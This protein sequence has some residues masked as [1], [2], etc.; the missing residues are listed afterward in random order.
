MTPLERITERVTRNGHP[1]DR[2]TPIPLLS[3][4]EFFDGNT[5]T[6]SIGCNVSGAPTPAQFR[7]MFEHIARQPTVRDV[8]IQITAFDE[9]EWPFSDTVYIMTSVPL[10]QVGRWFPEHL[11]PDELWE[12]FSDTVRYEPYVVPAGT[13]AVACWWD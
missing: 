5:H 3:I 9:P 13:R 11:R 7:E 12:G 1:E 8:R 10:E 2:G 4:A 6:G